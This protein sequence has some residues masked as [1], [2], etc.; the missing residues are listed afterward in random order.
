MVVA[1]ANLHAVVSQITLAVRDVTL[2]VVD[3]NRLADAK[4]T[5]VAVVVEA[6]VADA[7]VVVYSDVFV[8]A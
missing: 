7:D 5:V 1:A 3:V 2:A 4:A 8:V 6:L